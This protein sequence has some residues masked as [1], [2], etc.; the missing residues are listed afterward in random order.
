MDSCWY[1]LSGRMG[2]VDPLRMTTI[3]EGEG[4]RPAP[5]RVKARKDPLGEKV[6]VQGGLQLEVIDIHRAG[7]L[8]LQVAIL[9][10]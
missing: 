8:I 2:T 3:E 9:L 4:L 5:T 10:M 1:R 6:L 7:L